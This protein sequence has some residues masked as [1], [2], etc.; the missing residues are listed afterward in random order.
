MIDC[1]DSRT[2]TEGGPVTFAKVIKS[3]RA[4]FCIFTGMGYLSRDS[5]CRC[6]R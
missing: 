4:A 3:N 5:L 6:E 2:F 1:Q